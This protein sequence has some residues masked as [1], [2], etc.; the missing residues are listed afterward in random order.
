MI[1][2]EKLQNKSKEVLRVGIIRKKMLDEVEK[3]FSV[4]VLYD[5]FSLNG[6]SKTTKSDKKADVLFTKKSNESCEKILK[7]VKSDLDIN[8]DIDLQILE[9]FPIDQY[10]SWEMNSVKGIHVF[11]ETTEEKTL[12]KSTQNFIKKEQKRL[13]EEWL[14]IFNHLL[15][16]NK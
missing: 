15:N 3:Y 10:L 1:G 12:A 2:L 9:D 11:I 7:K 14:N 5:K 8:D 13:N 16:K 4:K 6:F